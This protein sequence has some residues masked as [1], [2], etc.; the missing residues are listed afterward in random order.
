VLMS[1]ASG[2]AIAA[3]GWGHRLPEI[4]EYMRAHSLRYCPRVDDLRQF[5]FA[6]AL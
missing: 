5:L 1:E 4:E 6:P 2:V 3:A